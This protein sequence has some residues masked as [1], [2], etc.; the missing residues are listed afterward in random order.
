MNTLDAVVEKTKSLFITSPEE[1]IESL[2][3]RLIGEPKGAADFKDLL[4]VLSEERYRDA[5]VYE[6][7]GVRNRGDIPYLDAE[8]RGIRNHVAKF[9]EDKAEEERR[10]DIVQRSINNLKQDIE[11]VLDRIYGREIDISNMKLLNLQFL[12]EK[13]TECERRLSELRNTTDKANFMVRVELDGEVVE[14]MGTVMLNSAR[15]DCV[16]WRLS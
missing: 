2:L 15:T 8:F 7:S 11:I 1:E 10:E 13:V 9:N 4:V 5:A 12:K 14:A 3:T 16:Y 6:D